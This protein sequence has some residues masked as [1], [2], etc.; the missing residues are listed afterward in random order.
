MGT[1]E[2]LMSVPTHNHVTSSHFGTKSKFA[3]V[4]APM[5]SAGFDPLLMRRPMTA[6]PFSSRNIDFPSIRNGTSAGFGYSYDDDDNAGARGKYVPMMTAYGFRHR[7]VASSS[8][9]DEDLFSSRFNRVMHTSSLFDREQE[10][11]GSKT[12]SMIPEP[13]F[14]SKTASNYF[15]GEYFE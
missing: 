2:K 8:A 7:P 3:T 14:P 12:A 9:F 15:A 11:R 5:T 13:L 10:M 4:G 6:N 1:Y